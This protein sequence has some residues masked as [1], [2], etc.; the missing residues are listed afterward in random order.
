[1][2]NAR[3]SVAAVV[4]A[5]LLYPAAPAH[6]ESHRGP[7]LVHRVEHPTTEAQTAG[8]SV[9]LEIPGE[10]SSRGLRQ[11]GVGSNKGSSP[12][13]KVWFWIAGIVIALIVTA[14]YAHQNS[15]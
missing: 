2:M 15:Q 11:R 8:K 13:P 3:A 4:L 12:S 6:A 7:A 14:D 5:V 1:M 10:A 9:T